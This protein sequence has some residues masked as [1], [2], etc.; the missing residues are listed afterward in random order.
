MIGSIHPEPGRVKS[1]FL[2]HLLCTAERLSFCKPLF[3]ALRRKEA[4][5]PQAGERG[6]G[7]WQGMVCAPTGVDRVETVVAEPLCGGWK[8]GGEKVLLRLGLGELGE[9][10]G[11]GEEEVMYEPEGERPEEDGGERAGGDVRPDVAREGAADLAGGGAG[12]RVRAVEEALQAGW[13]RRPAAV[14]ASSGVEARRARAEGGG[15][16]GGGV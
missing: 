14:R 2:A 1:L 10:G 4:G 9:G 8:C 11:E 15:V 12:G 3:Q 16:W 13:R 7:S 6:L 5:G